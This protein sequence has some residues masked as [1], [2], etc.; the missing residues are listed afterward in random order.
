[1]LKLSELIALASDKEV[2]YV[3]AAPVHY[4]V[5]PNKDFKLTC[6]SIDKYNAVLD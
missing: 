4:I 2:A 1:M 6:K 5:L 3:H